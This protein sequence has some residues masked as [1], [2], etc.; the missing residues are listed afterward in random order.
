MR[1]KARA[2]WI[3]LMMLSF[4]MPGVRMMPLTSFNSSPSFLTRRSLVSKILLL[5][6]WVVE[7]SCEARV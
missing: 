5:V 4:V 1:F 7:N 6:V 3:D 2:I